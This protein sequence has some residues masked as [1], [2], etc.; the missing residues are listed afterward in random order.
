LRLEGSFI[1][2]VEAA[3]PHIDPSEFQRS[4]VVEAMCEHL[5]AVANG[6]IKR[7][8]ITVPPRCSKTLLASVCF[9]AWIF[10]QRRRSYLKGPQCKILA[11]SY[12]HSLS[13]TNSNQ[14]RRLILSP[15]YQSLWPTRFRLMDDQ[16]TK[17]R[18]DTDAGGSRISTSVGGSLLGIG[19]D[20]VIC[21]DLHD[22]S[23]IES[24]ADRETVLRF[25][26]EVSSTRLNNPKEAAVIVVQQRL[27]EEDTVGWIYA[28]AKEGEWEHLMVPMKFDT[29]RCCQTSIGWV[30]PRGCDDETGEPLLAFPDRQP[31]SAE[32]QE[33]LEQ[34]EGALLWPARFGEAEVAALEA[35][36]GPYMASGRLQQAPTPKGGGIIR[37]EW[38]QLYDKVANGNKYPT[39]TFRVASLDGAYTD[40]EMNDPSAMTVWGVWKPPDAAGPRIILMDC[41]RKW[42]TL[43]GN[44]T[45]R[46]PDEI[47]QPGDT[48]A[49]V[50]Q[51]DARYRQR[52][53]KQW[54]LVEWVRAT[55]LKFDVD[56]LLIEKAASGLSVA[57][58]LQRMYAT[59]GIAVYLISP[60]G[61]KVARCHAIVP[62][63]SQGLVYAPNISW[64][65][66]LLLPELANFPCGKHDD[67]VD[68]TTMALNFLRT[69]GR[70]QTDVEI[71]AAER[72]RLTHR[73]PRRLPYRV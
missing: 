63:L 64:S 49:V 15:W 4:W 55:C 65:D 26:Q 9:P 45:P 35:S 3:W 50:R 54:G 56:V 41:W 58:E 22:V 34:R 1:D 36:L 38:F 67:L 25:F 6:E 30:D 69:T 73:A 47:A 17:L 70:I 51:R 52:A 29:Q 59:D 28:N 44:P 43:H 31:V 20:L 40:N 21:D 27:H 16:N 42:L 37:T 72:E 7:L 12:G 39:T 19:G 24:E 5:E 8:T 33:I 68:S 2:F 53:G 18:F 10:A 14:T 57:Q 71:Q 60:K 61:D 13:I 62:I 32:A 48:E 23:G 66:D 46:T 11:A